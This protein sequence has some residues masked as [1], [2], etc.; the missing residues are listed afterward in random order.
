MFPQNEKKMTLSMMSS[1][2]L[3]KLYRSQ[4]A[5]FSDPKSSHDS[6]NLKM[7]ILKLSNSRPFYCDLD[8][9]NF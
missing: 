3:R 8:I 9:K 7:L 5:I 2:L 6:L 4:N 1:N